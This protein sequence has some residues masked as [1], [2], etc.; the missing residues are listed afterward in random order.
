MSRRQ[1]GGDSLCVQALRERMPC[2]QARVVDYA[3]DRAGDDHDHRCK[4]QR[5]DQPRDAR[6]GATR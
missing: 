5:Q 6:D 3:A 2:A 1:I 4:G